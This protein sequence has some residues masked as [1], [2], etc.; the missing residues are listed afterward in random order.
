[1]TSLLLSSQ[2]LTSLRNGSVS[3]HHGP[4]EGLTDTFDKDPSNLLAIARELAH[5]AQDWPGM[6]EPAQRVWELIDSSQDFE[7][8]VIG[9]PP[10]GAIQLHD[11]GESGGAVL[12]VQG[13]LVESVSSAS[14]GSF[15]GE[16]R[17]RPRRSLQHSQPIGAAL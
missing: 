3:A 16:Q 15:T 14:C 17:E 9:W 1:M 2:Q 7:A 12:V 4:L 13:E 10:G 6:T 5:D 8:W 11:H